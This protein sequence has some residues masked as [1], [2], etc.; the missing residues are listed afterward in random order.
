MRGL[1]VSADQIELGCVKGLSV[2]EDLV[3]LG[4][5]KGLSVREDLVELGRV[6]GLSVREDQ[7]ELDRVRGLSVREDLVELCHPRTQDRLLTESVDLRQTPDTLLDVVFEH[8]CTVITRQ[9]YECRVRTNNYSVRQQRRNL[10]PK[11]QPKIS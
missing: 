1:S 5:V 4:C 9:T 7:V 2:R 8:L 11:Q 10:T 3:E 6:R